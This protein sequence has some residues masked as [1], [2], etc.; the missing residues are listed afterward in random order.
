MSEEWKKYVKD[1]RKI[2]KYGEK[3]YQKN[4]DHHKTYKHPPQLKAKGNKDKRTQNRFKPYNKKT[5]THNTCNETIDNENTDSAVNSSHEEEI[6]DVSE[7]ATAVCR[8][9]DVTE[10]IIQIDASTVYFSK[11]TDN[12]VY[13]E[14]FKVEMPTDFFKFYECL[15]EESS[16]VE[17]LMASVNLEMIGPFD[18]LLGKLPKLDK[19]ELYLVHWRFFYDVPEFQAVLKKKGNSELHIGY[20]RDE[21]NEK[22]VFLAKNDSFKDY[23]IS[24]IA[25]NIFGA[26]YWFLQNE[27]K[28]SPFI[29]VACQKLSEKV[30]KW[31]E[32]NNY[33]IEEYDK[34]KRLKGI[35]C[36]TFHGAGIVVP[37]NKKTQLGYRK[38]VETD[39]NIKKMFKKLQDASME[40][41]KTK[42]LSE[43][44]PLITYSSIAVDECDFG[45]GLEAGI[46]LFCSGHKEFQKSA[47]SLLSTTYSL[48]KRDEF[49]EIIQMHIKH[50]RKG[51]HMALWGQKM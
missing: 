31:A 7:T 18:L 27:K 15:N 24:P 19:K 22:P 45:T 20:Y 47:L 12:A 51:P 43:L 50:R 10:N 39:A 17:H 48:L 36:K 13:K 49:G 23:T 35:V 21:P 32:S 2:C 38:L 42:I 40:S 4:P 14:C 6:D 16:S 34:K 29:S 30:K 37:Y 44:Q 41:E 5:N 26:V 46:A 8:L 33:S 9:D 11:E 3:C 28:S 25:E 1:P